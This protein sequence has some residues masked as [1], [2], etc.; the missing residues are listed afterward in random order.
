M[1][2]KSIAK[3]SYLNNLQFYK[4]KEFIIMKIPKKE[5]DIGMAIK[6]G[7]FLFPDCLSYMLEVATGTLLGDSSLVT[8]A[9]LNPLTGF[10]L[11]FV[12]SKWQYIDHLYNVFS[13]WTRA[14]VYD[15]NV[16]R[17]S[18]VTGEPL[19]SCWGFITRVQKILLPFETWRKTIKVNG[20]IKMTKILPLD[21]DKLLSPRVLNYW[22]MDDGSYGNKGSR[23]FVLC[24][25]GFS[26]NEVQKL[27]DILN[28]NY[29]LNCT[30]YTVTTKRKLIHFRIRI[31]T[32]SHLKFIEIVQ[33]Y[34]LTCF[35]Y[36]IDDS[37]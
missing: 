2:T 30:M 8:D 12:S 19:E 6:D 33:P 34:I 26:Q 36:K 11:Q 9:K 5:L 22:F 16:G 35:Q 15:K 7:S 1:Q 20:K 31:P 25:D 4:K 14:K 32:F 21:I 13:P 23:F 3:T 18:I 10:S 17:K 29:N 27:I 28:T 37:F 24:T